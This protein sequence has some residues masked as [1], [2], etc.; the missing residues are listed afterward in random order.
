MWFIILRHVVYSLLESFLW[1]CCTAKKKLQLQKVRYDILRKW[2]ETPLCKMHYLIIFYIQLHTS[3]P[4]YA[5]NISTCNSFPRNIRVSPCFMQVV[6]K[7]V[8]LHKVFRQLGWFCCLAA[9]FLLGFLFPHIL[10]PEILP[11]R[12][13]CS[14]CNCT[15]FKHFENWK[16]GKKGKELAYWCL[17]I[18]IDYSVLS[19]LLK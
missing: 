18:S 2:V 7:K 14:N 1:L 12:R 4:M 16:H 5:L 15:G 10:V 9:W 17:S 8:H 6:I 11:P 3:G 19:S 13:A